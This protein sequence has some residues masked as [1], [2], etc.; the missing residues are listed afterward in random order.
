M[1]AKKRV[2]G[3]LKNKPAAENRMGYRDS[4]YEG[5]RIIR[6]IM[7][8]SALSRPKLYVPKETQWHRFARRPEESRK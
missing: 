2:S 7:R 5:I 4:D 8:K 6:E 1:T 3:E